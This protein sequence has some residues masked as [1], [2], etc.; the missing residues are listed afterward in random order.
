MN[1]TRTI[2]KA[3]ALTA[4]VGLVAVTSPAAVALT[5]VE[6]INEFADGTADTVG[7]SFVVGLSP[8]P[9]PGLTA[10][11]PD[12][13]I[14]GDPVV[15][16]NFRLWHGDGTFDPAPGTQ[17]FLAISD[18]PFFDWNGDPDGSLTPNVS[19]MLA[20]SENSFDPSTLGTDVPMDFTFGAS[21]VDME[22]GAAYSATYV[23]VDGSNNLTPTVVGTMLLAWQFDEVQGIWVPAF[24]Y[25]AQDQFEAS[26]LFVDFTGDGL[27]G[28][29]SFSCDTKF[30]VT[31]STV[32]AL[33]GDLD[34]DGFVGIA[35]LN[36]V[37]G[38]WNAN[39]PVNP[40]ADPSGDG[41]VGIEDLNTVLG[42]W[43]AGTPPSAVAVP[44]PASVSLLAIGGASAVLARRRRS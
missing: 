4:T 35:D 41:F 12:N 39:P 17:V 13:G 36:I 29:C 9:D 31:L 40:A 8:D 28:Q 22:Y 25:G 20:V 18:D 11:D 33:A 44:E 1:L 10:A 23:T 6:G 32:T 26:A 15:M 34:G 3:S 21:G 43:N 30:E 38:E 37:L 5:F 7:Q 27:L 2:G 24:D 14:V 19:D 42:N 16:S